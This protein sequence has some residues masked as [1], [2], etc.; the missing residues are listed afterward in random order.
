V[1]TDA[2]RY[3]GIIVSFRNK[4]PQ[5]YREKAAFCRAMVQEVIRP[6]IITALQEL[7]EELEAAAA[8]LERKPG[9]PKS[10]PDAR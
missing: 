9:R 1:V 10:R 8:H 3:R 5:L 4:V 2:R 6:E 7:A